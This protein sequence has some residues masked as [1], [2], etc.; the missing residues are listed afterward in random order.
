[1]GLTSTSI[2]PPPMENNTVAIRS[3]IYEEGNAWGNNANAII[4]T[5]AKK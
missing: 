4:P 5:A 1:M 2:R 3:P